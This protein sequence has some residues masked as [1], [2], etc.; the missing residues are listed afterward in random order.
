MTQWRRIPICICLTSL[1][2]EAVTENYAIDI[3][4]QGGIDVDDTF[5]SPTGNDDVGDDDFIVPPNVSAQFKLDYDL[6]ES[7]VLNY[8]EISAENTITYDGKVYNLDVEHFRSQFSVF[9]SNATYMH[10][11]ISGDLPSVNIFTIEDEEDIVTVQKNF[12]EI[13]KTIFILNKESG[14]AVELHDIYF[15]VLATIRLEDYAEIPISLLMLTDKTT[16]YTKK[17][18]KAEAIDIHDMVIETAPCVQ[19]MILELAVAYD[20]SYCAHYG[21]N[22][23]IVDNEIASLVAMVST[24]YQQQELCVK[25]LISHLDGYCDPGEDPYKESVDAKASGCKSDDGSGLLPF[26]QTFWNINRTYVHRDVVQFFSATPLECAG[27]Q[28]V[29]GCAKLGTTCIKDDAYSVIWATFTENINFRSTV[30]AHELG[31][32]NDAPHYATKNHI[33]YPVASAASL[34]FGIDSIN[35]ILAHFSLS[36]CINLETAAP[37]PV[38]SVAPSFAP[39]SESFLN[40]GFAWLVSLLSVFVTVTIS[41]TLTCY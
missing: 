27:G 11:G 30:V 10:N 39:E 14:K 34:G 2:Y 36:N 31:H 38:P 29:A 9:T 28:C 35:F 20:S 16:N 15:G 17:S 40:L 4:I 5:G 3:E 18:D 22:V 37:S 12:N 41:I 8:Q 32:N 6:I 19:Y 13:V 23:D 24:R 7:A 25:V 33:M 26:V 1:F 21:G